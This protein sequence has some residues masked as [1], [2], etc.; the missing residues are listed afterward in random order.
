MVYLGINPHTVR[1]IFGDL[2]IG[3][4]FAEAL[5]VRRL[6]ATG[7]VVVETVENTGVGDLELVEFR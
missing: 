1:A 6:N 7:K 4:E 2:F 5:I 3:K